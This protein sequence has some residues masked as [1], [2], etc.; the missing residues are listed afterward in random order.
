MQMEQ[1]RIPVLMSVADTIGLE[2]AFNLVRQ[3]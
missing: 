3:P 1:P 2:I